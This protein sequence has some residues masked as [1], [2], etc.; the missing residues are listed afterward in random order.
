MLSDPNLQPLAPPRDRELLD[1][2]CGRNSL[3]SPVGIQQQLTDLVR[4]FS[5]V[6]YENLTKI[7]KRAARKEPAAARR[8]PQEVLQEFHRWG[9]GGTCFSL[10]AALLHLVRALGVEAEPILADRRYGAD[11]HCALIVWI[12]RQPHLLD[13]GYLIVDPIPLRSTGGQ[14][15]VATR[16]NQLELVPRG[17]DQL[18]LHTVQQG[19]RRFRLTF[20][21]TPA[22]TEQF[23]RAWDA[24]FAWEMM[25]YPVL[26][27]VTE[28]GQLYL[29]GR[30]LQTRLRDE[31]RHADIVES[32]LVATIVRTFG[33][34]AEV[35]QRALDVLRQQGLSQCRER[36]R[37]HGGQ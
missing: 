21:T 32:E 5:G 14:L 25:T 31:V 15:V 34:A 3:D 8:G 1:A 4:A 33:I 37:L 20:K 16:F 13:P 6:P 26:T 10:T 2:F 9:T 35:V 7:A 36:P 23:L 30:H 28:H 18:D 17:T 11:T 22:D 24:S 19:G 27:R 29:R 12:A